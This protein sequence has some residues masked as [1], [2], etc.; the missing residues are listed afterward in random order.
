MTQ[1]ATSFDILEDLY[2]VLKP[3]FADKISGSVYFPDC[4]LLDSNK[5]DA[6]IGFSNGDTEQ[7][8]TGDLHVNVFIPDI[9]NGS[10]T[11]VPNT[12]RLK[13]I[14]DY[15]D[16]LID[17]LN[18]I[19]VDSYLFKLSKATDFFAETSTHE[20]FVAFYINFQRKTF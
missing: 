5:E 12:S 4:R 19:Y 13:V 2:H 1:F 16:D 6:I 10:G 15:G 17:N 20:H 3:F 18:V 7:I 14:A 9:D 8:Q 11:K